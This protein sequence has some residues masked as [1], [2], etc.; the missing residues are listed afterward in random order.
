MVLL[1]N[2][3]TQYKHCFSVIRWLHK[4]EVEKIASNSQTYVVCFQ[5][6]FYHLD[7][8]NL[9]RVLLFFLV[10]FAFRVN[11]KFRFATKSVNLFPDHKWWKHICMKYISITKYIHYFTINKYTRNF[12]IDKPTT[13]Q[14]SKPYSTLDTNLGVIFSSILN[15]T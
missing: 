6:E 1:R 14:W 12:L 2:L 11:K 7:S 5:A 9:L 13:D 4:V 3:L 8:L 15:R 10:H